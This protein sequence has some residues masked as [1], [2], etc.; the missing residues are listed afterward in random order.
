MDMM[1]LDV[2][3]QQKLDC[4]SVTLQLL[5]FLTL[6]SYINQLYTHLLPFDNAI[7]QLATTRVYPKHSGL[8]L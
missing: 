2:P 5:T 6:C 8:T 1:T 7:Y 3:Q 4:R